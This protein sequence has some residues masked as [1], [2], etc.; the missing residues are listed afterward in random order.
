M[1]YV[2]YDNGEKFESNELNGIPFL[3]A[4]ARHKDS[5]L[6]NATV[7][8]VILKDCGFYNTFV[9]TVFNKCTFDE[10]DMSLCTFRG[11][12]LT[13][14]VVIGYDEW[15]EKDGITCIGKTAVSTTPNEEIEKIVGGKVI[16]LPNKQ[17]V[18]VICECDFCHKEYSQIMLR[19]NPRR[20][21]K[22]VPNCDKYVCDECYKNYRLEEKIEENR[23]YG[24]AGSLSFYRTPMDKKNTAI[25]GLEMEFEGDF[26]GW[27]GLQDAHKGQLH[28]GYDS[29]VRGKNELSWD[30][31]SYSWWKYL[32]NL[33][34]VCEALKAGGGSEGDTAGIHIHVSRPDVNIYETTERLNEL[35][36]SG[37]WM[38]L[39]KAVSLRNDAERFNRYASLSTCC[40]EHHAAISYNGHRTCEFRVFNSSLDYKLILQHLLFCKTIF[41]AIADK[42]PEDQILPGL[43]KGIKKY[44]VKCADIQLGK[45]FIT[46]TEYN[47]LIKA[48]TKEDK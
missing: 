19:R 31:G 22:Q 13:D 30:C 17:Y 47:K 10:C 39:M 33:K 40:A 38:T 36:Q 20:W 48:L 41:N 3:Q 29:S 26:Y 21:L 7:F 42:V 2:V 9:N 46:K 5:G 27:K 43:A 16:S 14:C 15:L 11:C 4:A 32:S 34:D 1:P 28:Y 12:K 25:L 44:I 6:D 23:H 24:Y 37:V 8:N 18:K 35:C 45:E